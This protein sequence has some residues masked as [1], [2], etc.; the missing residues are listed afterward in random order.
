MTAP[1]KGP[2]PL[3]VHLAAATTISANSVAAWPLLRSGWTPWKENLAEPG[4]ALQKHLADVN[5]EAFSAALLMELARRNDRFLTGLEA[6]RRH[7]YKRTLVP[8]PP[9][10]E[11]GPVQLQD[12]GA[13]HPAGEDGKPVLV[14]PSLVNRSYIM[15][16]TAERSFLRYL[17]SKGLRPLL[18]D[19]GTPGKAELSQSL[20]TC[21]D[22]T[23]REALS[24][25]VQTGSGGPIPVVGYCMGGTL[26]TA[27]AVLEPDECQALVLLASPWDF[28]AG[29]G[30]PPAA[31]TASRPMLEQ[32]IA[33]SDCLP[34]DTLQ[35]MFFSLDPMLGWNKFRAFAD[36][37]P[38]SRKAELFVALED[39]LNDGVPLAADIAR[40][41]L[42]EWYGDN[43]PARN[44]WQI[45]ATVIDPRTIAMPTL[46][47]LPASDRIVP[48]A[49]AMALTDAIPGAETLTPAAG[50]IGMMV[51]GQALKRLWEPV[52]DW[53]HGL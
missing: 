1:R 42:F 37:D 48:P 50:H 20:D 28:H 10:W 34:V 52:A 40:T 49:S 17:A 30:G 21:I 24:I 39:W 16:L 26:A 8:P 35:S 18:L 15:D 53:L 4:N 23:L 32:I 44:A 41:C 5:P 2:R 45:A 19:W 22:G 43:T 29:T 3:P 13:T 31:L 25:A 51:G 33:L 14:I 9:L 11:R 47:V 46:G 27:L 38:D 7:P 12:F 36:L 6:Y